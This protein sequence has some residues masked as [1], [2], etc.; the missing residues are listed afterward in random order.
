MERLNVSRVW[1]A[2][3]RRGELAAIPR[4]DREGCSGEEAG[5]AVGRGR[6]GGTNGAAHQGTIPMLVLTPPRTP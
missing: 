5:Q 1:A 2:A 3:G 4:R 6:T